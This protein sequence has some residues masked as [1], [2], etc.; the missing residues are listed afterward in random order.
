V[1]RI[2]AKVIRRL[3]LIAAG[4]LM[5]GSILP[6][7]TGPFGIAVSGTTQ[8]DGVITLILGGILGGLAFLFPRRWAAIVAAPAVLAAAATVLI[9]TVRFASTQ[10]VAV[11]Y[12]LVLADI[13]AIACVVGVI[14]TLRPAPK[15]A[16]ATGVIRADLGLPPATP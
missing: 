1:S 10:Y 2:N 12:G 4:A 8:G 14:L 16:P 6:W 11:G 3:T 13:A 9:D 7:A 5:V 15:A